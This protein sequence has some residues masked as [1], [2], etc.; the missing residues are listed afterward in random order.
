MKRAERVR[1][2]AEKR[3]MGAARDNRTD[4]VGGDGRSKSNRKDAFSQSLFATSFCVLKFSSFLMVFDHFVTTF[5]S[6]DK[7]VMYI[8]CSEHV[9]S[10]SRIYILIIELKTIEFHG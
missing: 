5:C 2:V 7:V 9:A 4:G 10:I 1:E 8:L 6:L 3:E